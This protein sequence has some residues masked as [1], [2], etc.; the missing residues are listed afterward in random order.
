MTSCERV[1]ELIPWYITGRIEGVD[2][3][4]VDGHLE[5]CATCRAELV[6]AM[7]VRAATKTEVPIGDS[8]DRVWGQV[9]A[10]LAPDISSIDI[11][12]FLLGLN[13]GVVAGRGSGTVRGSLRVLGRDV[14]ILGRR[15]KEA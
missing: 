7:R 1:R 2:A 11:G 4:M 13:F 12:S 9:D 8:I 15:R 3:E 5:G 14:P 6:E 10:Q